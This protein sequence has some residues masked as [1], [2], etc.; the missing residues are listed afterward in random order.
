L[1][2]QSEVELQFCSNEIQKLK[3]LVIALKGGKDASGR[4][5]ELRTEVSMLQEKVE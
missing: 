3:T 4:E 5:R 1:K 2:K